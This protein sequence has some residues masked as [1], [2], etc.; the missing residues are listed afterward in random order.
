MGKSNSNSKK[1][2]KSNRRDDDH[3]QSRNGRDDHDARGRGSDHDRRGPEIEIGTRH[4]D[5]IDKSDASRG[6]VI[7]GRQGDDDLTGSDFRDI[8]NGNRGDD[9]IEGG[10]GND[11]MNGGSGTDTAVFSGSI[12]DYTISSNWWCN[13]ITV[14]GPDGCDTLVGFEILEFDDYTFEIGGENPP[15]VVFDDASAPEN[16]TTTLSVSV[17]DIGGTGATILS[18]NLSDTDGRPG[19]GTV[20]VGAG[21]PIPTSGG[22][23]AQSYDL[24]FDP[25]TAFDYLSAGESVVEQITLVIDDGS[26]GT[27]TI[28]SDLTIEGLNDGISITSGPQAATVTEIA[29]GAPGE[30]SATLNAAGS[31]DFTDVDL[32]DTHTVSVVPGASGYLGAFAIL[33]ADSTGSGAGSVGWSFDVADAALDGLAMGET[34]VQ[35]YAVTLDDGQGATATDTVT[36]TLVGENDAP[37]L[38]AGTAEAFEGGGP[39]DVDLAALADDVDSDDDATTLTYLLGAFAGPGSV[40]LVSSTLTFDPG[41]DF[42]ALANGEEAE[43]DVEVIVVDTHGASTSATVTVTVIGTNEAPTAFAD[44]ASTDEDDAVLV[45]VLDNDSD[46]DAGDTLSVIAVS[47][48]SGGG[49]AGIVGDQVEWTPGGDY[50]DLAVGETATVELSYTIADQA[51]ETSTATVTITVLGTNDGPVAVD[52]AASPTPILEDTVDVSFSLTANDSDPDGDP[53]SILG[54]DD[55]GTLGDVSV[56]ANGTD[57]TVGI[58]GN[59]DFLAVGATYIDSFDYTVTDGNGG[60]DTATATVTVE[61]ENDG[62]VANDDNRTLGESGSISVAV[63]A[64]DTDVDLG[65]TLSVIGGV[66]YTPGGTGD[67]VGDQITFDT[68]GDFEYLAAGESVDVLI[69]YVME[70]N[71]GASD[72]ALVTITVLGENDGPTANDDTATVNEDDLVAAAI[73]LTGND[74][75]V[76]LSD[77]IEVLSIDTTGTSGIVISTGDGD[78]FTY[79]PS[80][81]FE[82]LGAGE[83]A[84][85]TFTYTVTDGNGGQ[86]SATVSVTVMGQND[87][88]SAVS[89]NNTG[90]AVVE[91]GYADPVGQ[92]SAAGKVLANDSDVDANDV[93]AVVQVSSGTGE[94]GS[95]MPVTTFVQLVLGRYGLL[96][97]GPDGDWTYTLDNTDS[98]TEALVSGEIAQETFTYT[99][100]DGNGGTDTATL[101]ID[102]N[103]ADDNQAPVANDDVYSTDEDSPVGI[104]LSLLSNDSDADGDV[105][106]VY[107]I[108]GTLLT[109]PTTI[110]TTHGVVS[111]NGTFFSYTSDLNYSGPDSFTYEISDG[112]AVSNTA[113]VDIDIAPVADAPV[114]VP[115]P[116]AIGTEDTAGLLGLVADLFDTDGSET[117]QLRFSGMP[118]GSVFNIGYAD[119]PE[120]VIEGTD[121]ASLPGLTFTPPPD[122]FGLIQFQVDAIATETA[123]GDQ[124]TTTRLI[125]VDVAPV[126]DAP[127]AFDDA[128]TVAEGAALVGATLFTPFS[129]APPQDYDIDSAGIS[130]ISVAGGAFS[131]ETTLLSGFGNLTIRA[132][133]T[134]DLDTAGFIGAEQ[135][136]V[137]ET[138]TI[139]FDY[140]ITDGDGGT[141]IATATVTIVGAN[142]GPVAEDDLFNG[143][144]IGATGNVF[145]DNGSGADSDVDANDVL[146]VVAVNGVDTQ[147]GQELILLSGQTVQVNADG[148]FAF[149]SNGF[150]DGLGVGESYTSPILTYTVSDGQGATDTA[151]ISISIAGQNDGPVAVDDAFV[152]PENGA[153]TADLFRL[154]QISPVQ[155]YDPDITDSFTLTELNGSAA[156]SITL[157]SGAEVTVVDATTGDVFYNPLAAFDYLG[158]GETATDS[159]TYTIEDENGATDTGTVSVQI[160]GANDD[161]DAVNDSFTALDTGADEDTPITFAA[162]DLLGNDSDIDG[163]T[164]E[165]VAV[166]PTGTA[167]GTL[168]LNPDGSVDYSP[169]AAMQGLAAG[170]ILVETFTYTVS[171][172]NGGSD[173]ATV[174]FEIAG[175]NDAPEM[176]DQ[177]ETTDYEVALN[178]TL[179]GFDID[180]DSLSYALVPGEGPDNGTIVVN[181]DGSYVYTPN[182]GFSG[183]DSFQALVSDGTASDTATITVDVGP[184]TTTGGQTAEVEVFDT[185][186]ISVDLSSLSGSPNVNVMFVMDSSGSVGSSGWELTKDA[187]SGLMTELDTQFTGTGVN[188]DFAVINFSNTVRREIEFTDTFPV[189]TMTALVDTLSWISSTTATGDAMLAAASMFYDQTASSDNNF[190]YLITDGVPYPLAAQE[191]RIDQADT[192]LRAYGVTTEVVAVGNFQTGNVEQ[193]D[194]DGTILAVSSFSDLLDSVGNSALFQLEVSDATVSLVADATDHGQLAGLPDFSTTAEGL[195]ISLAEISGIA[196]LLG[197]SNTFTTSVTVDLDPTT[198]GDEIVLTTIKT[199][200]VKA[201]SVNQAGTS[202]ADLIFG[203]DEGDTLGGAAGDDILMGFD[204]DDIIFGGAGNDIATGGLGADQ[205]VFDAE[206]GTETDVD[207]IRDFELGVD[208]L[209]LLGG[210]TIA[211][212][213]DVDAD[214]D[215]TVDDTLVTLSNGAQV[216]LIDVSG[217][218][219]SGDLLW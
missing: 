153:Y 53:L 141:D 106:F 138:G 116:L 10:G 9:R 6:Q 57:V 140:T 48:T 163:D 66:K 202:E 194:T 97:I 76:D 128:F 164:L 213:A 115:Q 131:G 23:D 180:G 216:Q 176:A 169:A 82:A 104:P 83:S 72:N 21:T 133:G 31:I 20:T 42:N 210:L 166:S 201:E 11:F 84:V 157:A 94:P 181:P 77:D 14:R 218:V 199:L 132:D 158:V 89:D 135:L 103:G 129:S 191:T 211:S 188:L 85:D 217:I 65:D 99:I 130:V 41:S 112:I 40:S 215:S 98:D 96:A 205:F 87:G 165:I 151:T 35:T 70:D 162:A 113:T 175:V 25:G 214:G 144:Q 196:E 12:L 36:I 17:Y 100:S 120:W 29:D 37:T 55:T 32:N 125:S 71:H 110:N 62:P 197:R 105:P 178:A 124:A 208:G 3:H 28:T 136:G 195:A 51:G 34:L 203:S 172:G 183:S 59:F 150:F 16:G 159:F 190:I 114:V 74:T 95:D 86:D 186:Q 47:V 54:I 80:G 46:P 45:S 50:N 167:G 119:G 61:G 148:T 171:D 19:T 4:D 79:D 108:N 182:S 207:T 88:P 179:S 69:G 154:G 78:T 198:T 146:T 90:A 192:A 161:P 170:D 117:L 139:T 204:G 156:P 209:D 189:S 52:D 111:F 109:G 18:A 101:T 39:V 92:D 13:V 193:L 8:I 118:A 173:S 63:L 15:L 5:V 121:L 33:L 168:A 75:D 102:I 43:V 143:D 91:A 200:G 127:V 56:D 219:S 155:D 142:D 1:N 206:P 152:T 49:T 126:N 73:N 60:T 177:S 93:L 185:G 184:Y 212:V 58:A 68:L 81:Q 24:T 7:V 137:G 67:I 26:G 122:A 147:V 2:D 107:S 38:D 145:D 64:N 22:T 27:T 174:S 44:T 149:S 134:L 30:G 160:V 123:N 187:V